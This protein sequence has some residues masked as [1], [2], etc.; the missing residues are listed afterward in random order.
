[1]G[2]AFINEVVQVTHVLKSLGA[3]SQINAPSGLGG[4]DAGR[5][6]THCHDPT[7]AKKL[8]TVMIGAD[9]REWLKYLN[10]ETAPDGASVNNARKAQLLSTAILLSALLLKPFGLGIASA[11]GPL[12]SADTHIRLLP[13]WLSFLVNE[14]AALT[15]TTETPAFLRLRHAAQSVMSSGARHQM[16]RIL[17]L[18]NAEST[19]ECV[20]RLLKE[21]SSVV[22]ANFGAIAACLRP[23]M[24]L[25]G[26]SRISG[27][28][29]GLA[30]KNPDDLLKALVPQLLIN[31]RCCA[32][33]HLAS[34]TI[35]SEDATALGL[36][37]W[38]ALR[39]SL[40]QAGV[41]GSP[42]EDFVDVLSSKLQEH[43]G[44]GMPSTGV[45]TCHVPTDLTQNMSH[46]QTRWSM[47]L[48]AT[49]P[50]PPTPRPLPPSP[51]PPPPHSPQK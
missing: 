19:E 14:V 22:V 18:G 48:W 30:A 46:Q 29:A 7:L 12:M 1:M 33:G 9:T 21:S 5:S 11:W 4:E 51:P 34:P 39:G 25:M 47:P 8:L 28:L 23:S 49:H 32:E 45:L 20:I 43:M 50:S 6:E 35:H 24:G 16:L 40:E 41:A 2:K 17:G 10:G 31:H 42:L 44:A 37:F 27:S 13:P 3:V 26:R 36:I 15:N 38:R